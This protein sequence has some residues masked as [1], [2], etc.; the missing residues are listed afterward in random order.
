MTVAVS[1]EMLPAAAVARMFG[2]TLRTLYNWDKAKEL[3]AVRHH[4]R[5]YYRLSDIEAFLSGLSETD[6]Q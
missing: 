6:R 1:D 4:R 2:C 3:V 5:R